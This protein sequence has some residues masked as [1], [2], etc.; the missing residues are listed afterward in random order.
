MNFQQFNLPFTSSSSIQTNGTAQTT[1]SSKF[2]T[3]TNNG[4]AQVVGLLSSD[5][6]VTYLRPVETNGFALNVPG[7]Q[8]QNMN[9][10]QTVS[11]FPTTK[12]VFSFQEVFFSFEAHH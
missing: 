6:G 5:D 3:A 7:Q 9:H 11:F 12:L 2:T 1:S 8:H 10:Q 4:G